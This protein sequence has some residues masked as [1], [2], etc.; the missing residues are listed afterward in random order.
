MTE[1]SPSAINRAFF[2]ALAFLLVGAL[3]G[4]ACVG[5]LIAPIV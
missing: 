1:L 2:T 4:L 3:V 5:P